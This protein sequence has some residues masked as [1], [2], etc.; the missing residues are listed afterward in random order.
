MTELRTMLLP[1]LVAAVI[2][3]GKVDA[4][5]VVAI[6]ANLTADGVIDNAEVEALFIMNDAVTGNDNAPE[7]EQCFVDLISENILDDGIIDAEEEARLIA[8]IG[9]DGQVDGAEK[10][11]LTHLATQTE[12][13]AGLQALLAA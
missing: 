5:E 11:L 12:L 10:A 4:D 2:A 7:W 8:L 9:A 3:D 1:A 13:P 6:R